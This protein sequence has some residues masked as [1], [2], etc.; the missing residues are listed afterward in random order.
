MNKIDDMINKLCVELNE[1]NTEHFK[2]Y[3]GFV[4]RFHK[5]SFGN[6]ILITVQNPLATRVASYKDWQSKF[7]RQVKKGA[8][9]IKIL[10]P[11]LK[12][13]EVDVGGKKETEKRLVSYS[14]GN[15][16]DVSDTEGEDC[17]EMFYDLGDEALPLY[18]QLKA[19]MEAKGIQVI[20]CLMKAQGSS[21]GRVVKINQTL[22]GTNKF[23]TLIHEYVHSILHFGSENPDLSV[24]LKECQA[25]AGAY[26]VANYFGVESPVSRDYLISWGN[27]SETLRKNLMPVISASK[28]IISELSVVL[29]QEQVNHNFNQEEQEAA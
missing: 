17:P 6:Q 22:D 1:G 12:T 13:V 19:I 14:V 28:E 15:V 16:F 9:G 26:I 5:Y 8:K 29:E 4:S 21:S 23:L 27:D 3:L 18:N 20:E 25:E 2:K 7:N 11:I 24:G 10:V